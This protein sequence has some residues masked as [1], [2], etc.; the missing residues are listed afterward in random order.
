MRTITRTVELDATPA[1]VWEV[2]TDA[3]A[4]ADW[5]PFITTMYGALEVGR[6]IEVRI[7]PPG[8][9][10]MTFRPTVT[11]VDPAHHLAW[12]GHLLLRGL[13][14]G[15]HSCPHVPLPDNRTQLTQSETFRGLLVFLAGG[16]LQ[17]T[18]AGFA[19]MNEALRQRLAHRHP[20]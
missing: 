4:H 2:L 12:L 14:D 16:L 20:A 9:K 18:E 8:G 6:R 7:A 10:T 5:N 11:H 13:V 3:R 17:R 15:G 19:A 1:Q